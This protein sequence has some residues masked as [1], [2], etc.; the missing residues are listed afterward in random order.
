MAEL[1]HLLSMEPVMVSGRLRTIY[2]HFCLELTP[3]ILR[4][5]CGSLPCRAFI[6]ESGIQY[7]KGNR[8]IRIYQGSA[9]MLPEY[10]GAQVSLSLGE[11]MSEME[12]RRVEGRVDG[13]TSEGSVKWG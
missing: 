12:E 6:L 4:G 2:E 1:L 13:V 9:Q 8:E 5:V 3:G 7:S 10:L 11:T